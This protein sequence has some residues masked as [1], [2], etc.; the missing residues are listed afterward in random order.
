M[1]EVTVIGLGHMGSALAR[2]FLADQ[3]EVTVWNR[4]PEKAAELVEQGAVLA[5]DAAAAAAASP[6]TVMC[7]TDHT[8][9]AQILGEIGENLAG[10]LL[11]QLSTSMPQEARAGEAWA[12]EH[13]VK[14]L[15]GAITGSPASIGTPGAHILLSGA[16]DAFHTAEPLLRV[17]AGQL[18]YKGAQVGMAPAW[19]II[20]IMHYYGMFLSLFHSV[21]VCQAEGIPLEQFS[22]LLGEQGKGYE[23]WLVDNILT[24][25]YD[26]TTAETGRYTYQAPMVTFGT[27]KHRL[28]AIMKPAR[29]AKWNQS[30]LNVYNQKHQRQGFCYF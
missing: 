1:S 24:G 19:D 27:S 17:L 23:K 14:Y 29:G 26:K 3:H 11:V 4:S 22:A 30:V 12:Q 21:Q 9:T 16:E 10:K 20:M 7:V 13:Q 2:A 8:A 5:P 18:D 28:A 25:S 6:V 15:Q